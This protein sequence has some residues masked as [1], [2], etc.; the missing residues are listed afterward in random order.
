[1][2]KWAFESNVLLY[3]LVR[4]VLTGGGRS[5][6]LRP[7]PVDSLLGS[8]A[9][10]GAGLTALVAGLLAAGL[11]ALAAAGLTALASLATIHGTAR[12]GR[13]RRGRPCG[14]ST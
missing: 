2:R 1:M 4:V 10:G 14:R 3:W 8:A 5:A 11:L 12:P 9:L 13:Q 7:P 6:M